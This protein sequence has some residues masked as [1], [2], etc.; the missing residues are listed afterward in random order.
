MDLN[1]ESLN[2][3]GRCFHNEL[4]TYNYRGFENKNLTIR[5]DYYAY[6]E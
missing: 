1:D 6:F 4:L 2:D 3:F 5:I